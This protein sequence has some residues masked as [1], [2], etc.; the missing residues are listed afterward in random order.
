MIDQD[1]AAEINPHLLPNEK[2]IWV[3]KPKKGI[4]FSSKDTVF[5]PFSI[6]WGGFAIFWEAMV[7][8]MGA[9]LMFPIFGIPFILVGLYLMIGRF[10]VDAKKRA[11]TLYAVTSER[12][13]IQTGLF[14][15]EFFST[16]IENIQNTSFT[17]KSDLSG[18]ISFAERTKRIMSNGS[19]YT[20]NAPLELE[21]IEDVKNVYQ[22]IIQ[23]QKRIRIN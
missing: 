5:I 2:I 12:I 13:I 9:P 19:E 16:N 4:L 1:L 11:N 14:S 20:S 3:G 22:K 18:T 10:F 21:F 23:Q 15:K 8:T 17:E 6:V 7:I